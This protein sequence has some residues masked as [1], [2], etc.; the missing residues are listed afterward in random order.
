MH[1]TLGS[2]FIGDNDLR[3][4]SSGRKND[5]WWQYADQAQS[6]ERHTINARLKN[7]PFTVS[8]DQIDKFYADIAR[9]SVVEEAPLSQL[10]T[11]SPDDAPF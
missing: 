10:D 5:N 2:S 11:Y 3:C 1:F 8:Q 4:K 7:E 9:E 6:V